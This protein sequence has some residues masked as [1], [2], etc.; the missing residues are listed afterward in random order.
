[1]LEDASDVA[2]YVI[3]VGVA[4][5][6]DFSLGDVRVS[7]E[8]LAKNGQVQIETEAV[9]V[10]PEEERGVAIYVLDAKG[11][12]QPRGQKTLHWRPGEPQA[13][14]F[15]LTGEDLGSH[16]GYIRI[17]GEDN[18]PADDT[19]YFTFD[20][21]PPFRVL[22]AAPKP[23]SR[24]ALFLTEALAPSALL[25]S[26]RARFE[27]ETIGLDQL[28]D[29]NLESYS[30]VCLLDPTPLAPA[31]WQQLAGYRSSRGGLHRFGWAGRCAASIDMFWP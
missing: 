24:Y 13:I 6:H 5:P 29:R 14:D 25:K 15:T 30:A 18:L 3:D 19:R 28:L 10:G 9:R 4:E 26:G 20:V 21:R 11:V 7:P 16:P 31:A 17:Q 1:M 23:T 8:V 2:I 12:P 27:C 22:V